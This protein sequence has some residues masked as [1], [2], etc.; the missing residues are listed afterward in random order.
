MRL[1]LV[2]DD[3]AIA[4]SLEITL[5]DSGYG[6]DR[7]REG[8]HA[9]LAAKTEPYSL[10]ILDLGL[11]DMD[12]IECLS[13]M[14]KKSVSIPVIILTARDTPEERIA[15]LDAGAN[16]YI[17]KPFHYGELEARIRAHL[18]VGFNNTPELQIGDL[19]WN[20]N[21]RL[22]RSSSE[23]IELAPKELA[24]LEILLHDLG[25]LV[26]KANMALMLSN[27]GES[28]TFNAIDLTVHRLRKKLEP[29]GL[30]IKTIRGLGF[31]V[32]K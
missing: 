24:V 7:V 20:S 6:V 18:R 13:A 14:R 17:A 22:L 1:L 26:T 16:D 11:P 10:I 30:K 19:T 29:F 5:R 8:Q 28:Q 15:G 23:V 12:G 21:E 2:E 32:E 27:A 9:L 4:H 31:V 25:T 3:D